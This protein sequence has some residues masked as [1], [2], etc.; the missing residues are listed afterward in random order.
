MNKFQFIKNLSI[1]N[2]I[3]AIILCVSITAIS[4]GFVFIATWDINRLTTEIQSNLILD[5]TLIGDYCVVP[6]TFDDNRQAT[7][8]L[9]RLKYLGSVESGFLFDKTG[10][11][12]AEYPDTIKGTS[13]PDISNSPN[14]LLKDGHFTITEP[15]VFQ[16]KILGTIVIIAN[17]NPLDIRRE[18]LGITLSVLLLILI[19][20]SYLLAVRMQRFISAPIISLKNNFTT[21][22]STQDYSVH[23]VKPYNDETGDLFDGFN[24][25]LET[26]DAQNKERKKL[27]FDLSESKSMLNIILDTIPQSIFWKDRNSV[28]IGC[29]KAFADSAGLEHPDVIIGKTD[30]ELP[31]THEAEKYRTDDQEVI[32]SGR[33]KYHIIEPLTRG[34]GERIWVD[35]TKIPLRDSDGKVSILIGVLEDITERK[36]AEENLKESE[37]RYRYLFEHNPVPMLIY[38]LA[39]LNILAVN[40]AFI[41]HYGYSKD[42]ASALHLT[43]LYPESEKK[44]IADLS[45]TLHGHAYAGEWH[46]RKKDGTQITIEA[47]SHGFSYEGRDARIAVINDLTDRKQAEEALRQS[48]QRY[49]QLLESITDYTYSVEIHNGRPIKTVHGSGCE[50]VTGYTPADYSEIPKLWLQMVHPEDRNTIEHY[51]DPLC[52]GK[53]IPAIEHRIIHKNGSVI[54]VRNTYVLKHNSGMVIGYDGL[55]SDITERKL[56][57]EEIRRLN[58]ELEDR[59]VKRTAQ[60]EA[61][62]KELEAFSYSVSHDLRAPLRHASGYVDLLV[63]RCTPDLSEKGRHY[64]DCIADSVHQMGMLIDDLLQFSRTGRAEMRRSISSMDGILDDVIESLRYDNPARTIEWIV[65]TLPPVYCDTAMMKLVWMNLLSNAVKFTRTREKAVI[66]IGVKE[67]DKEYVFFVRDNGVGF[68]MRYAQKL[69]GV[70]QRMHSMEEF[71]GTGIGLA[72]VQRIIIRHDG[73]TWAEAEL[74]KGATLYFTIPKHEEDTP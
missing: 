43:D 14:A 8:A 40:D 48:E 59:V 13:I 27:I 23:V 38:E 60:L 30:F 72:N 2:K 29:N 68:D 42:E 49:K 45:R 67:N 3:I 11:L 55:I 31:W 17:S 70:F 50:K 47:R 18:K 12:F 34:D 66:E 57:E 54:W 15:V 33:T 53:E 20:I 41:A 44:A 1:K 35:T 64:L 65:A 16:G 32:A 69:F 58:T 62:N 36:R 61:A 37:T 73:R 63:K 46:H 24:K 74:D 4:A 71:E 9:S 56:A 6:L 28:Y 21:I 19:V 25:L 26:I 39:R 52:E 51:A 7:E 5:A 22:A 10:K